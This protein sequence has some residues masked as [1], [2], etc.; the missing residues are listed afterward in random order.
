M[1]EILPI[2]GLLVQKKDVLFQLKIRNLHVTK[3]FNSGDSGMAL[4]NRKIVYCSNIWAE[5]YFA[6][7]PCLPCGADNTQ[8]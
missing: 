7:I 3:T 1:N 4:V 2:T 5:V 6:N 8:Y